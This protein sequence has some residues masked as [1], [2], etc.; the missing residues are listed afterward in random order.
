MTADFTEKGK[1]KFKMNE[2]VERI[3]EEFLMDFKPTDTV[4]TPASNN[5]FEIGNSKFLGK[6]RAEF[7]R[8]FVAKNLFLC[9]RV[10]PDVQP[11]VAILATRV[12]K[13]TES[14]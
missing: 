2:Y 8:T 13:P 11:T 14:N 12:Q 4:L 7:Y 6:G 10:R 9:K 1:V 3:L 5:L